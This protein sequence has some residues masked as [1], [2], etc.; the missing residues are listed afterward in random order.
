MSIWL[1]R[2]DPVYVP[3]DTNPF[4]NYTRSKLKNRQIELDVFLVINFRLT[5]RRLGWHWRWWSRNRRR[6]LLRFGFLR[7][8]LAV[9]R[10]NKFKLIDGDV[11]MV[12]RIASDSLNLD[13]NRIINELS[14]FC[15]DMQRYQTQYQEILLFWLFCSIFVYNW[16]T[17]VWITEANQWAK[18]LTHS[19]TFWIL[20]KRRTE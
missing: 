6:F 13:L 12:V 20:K 8:E 17:T 10:A 5:V 18:K 16:E 9:F 7:H 1:R 14:L 3:N 4:R 19:R 11:S 2:I 15:F